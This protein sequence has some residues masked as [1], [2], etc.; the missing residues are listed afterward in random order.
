MTKTVNQSVKRKQYIIFGFIS[1][2]VIFGVL[3]YLFVFIN[4]SKKT[5]EIQSDI[6]EKSIVPVTNNMS[7]Q[8][9]WVRKLED[10]N[11]IISKKIDQLEKII[12]DNITKDEQSKNFNT[13]DD[14]SSLQQQI[15]D[16]KNDL[17]KQTYLGSS[18]SE[19]KGPS[20]FSSSLN[21][22]EGHFNMN[23]D[24]HSKIV[25]NLSKKDIKE[26]K[27]IDNTIPAGSFAKAV[28]IGGIDAST[29]VT[30][31]SDPRPILMRLIDHGTL[32]RQFRS[33]VD[34]CHVLAGSYGD[35]SSE[36]VF[37]R[38]EKLTCV[39]RFSK[40]ILE[41]SV[42]GYVAGE[43]G[44][45]GVRGVV[46]DKTGPML[47]NTFIAGFLG[48]IG[49]FVEGA[50]RGSV[51][52]VSPF[53]QTNSMSPVDMLKSGAANGTSN[54][55]DKYADFWIKRAEQLQPVIQVSAGRIV[56]IVITHGASL[57]IPKTKISNKNKKEG[58][59]MQVKS[60]EGRFNGGEGL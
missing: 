25:L 45:A 13:V 35:L 2:F 59:L 50:N 44:K 54:A 31:S 37:M 34:D 10:E 56:D 55:F 57:I 29:S 17:E 60:E 6:S 51:F 42:S 36:R 15:S 22:P 18:H 23:R 52:P 46:V 47:R 12:I 16:L 8:E 24:V 28:L 26:I 27:H 5:K 30:S 7:F 53:G 14:I 58:Q 39:D 3:L 43:D 49:N 21:M 33:H 38:L 32:P 4:N 20:T 19:P 48:G 41:T 1:F 11:K 9:I 40:E